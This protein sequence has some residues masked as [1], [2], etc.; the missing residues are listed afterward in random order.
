M[1][2]FISSTSEQ[3]QALLDYNKNLEVQVQQLDSKNILNF[4]LHNK[5]E[6]L[7][8]NPKD[9]LGMVAHCH[10]PQGMGSAY[11]PLR[12]LLGACIIWTTLHH[13]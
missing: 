12:E 9:P 8:S 1:E 7:P 3:L 5:L 6:A 11:G 13:F 4:T 2:R 10:T